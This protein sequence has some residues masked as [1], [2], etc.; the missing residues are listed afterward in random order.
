MGM[1]RRVQIPDMFQG[2]ADSLGIHYAIR[3][4]EESKLG[5]PSFCQGYWTNEV[6]FSKMG[7]L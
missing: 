4:E 6:A 5:L 1:D 7:T 3:G 2:R